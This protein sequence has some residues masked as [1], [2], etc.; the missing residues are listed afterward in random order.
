MRTHWTSLTDELQLIL[1]GEA[2]KH[3]VDTIAGQA[4]CL[5]GEIENGALVDRGGPD[6]LR[7]L[8]S[9]LRVTSRV[10]HLHTAGHA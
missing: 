6:A 2:M 7:L 1:A 4:E 10:D 3:A 9:V 5:A 8:V